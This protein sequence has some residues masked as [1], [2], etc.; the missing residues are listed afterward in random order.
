MTPSQPTPAS[1]SVGS[2]ENTTGTISHASGQS[3]KANALWAWIG[4]MGLA[5]LPILLALTFYYRPL[6]TEG[7]A[8]LPAGGDSDFYIYQT[9]RMGELDGRWWEL[10]DDKLVG[11]PY[12]TWVA[13][14][15]GLYEGLDLLLVSSVTARFLD[16]V[17]NYHLL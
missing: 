10:G 2:V 17:A 15:P 1:A 5:L 6:F 8:T 7:F 13:R 3:G 9:A 4:R 14:H 12:P 16:P 11:Q